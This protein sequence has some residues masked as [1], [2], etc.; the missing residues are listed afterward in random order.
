MNVAMEEWV[1]GRASIFLLS[2]WALN[3]LERGHE[4]PN[5]IPSK[6]NGCADTIRNIIMET[7][8]NNIC[9]SGYNSPIH[10]NQR[11]WAKPPCSVS[12]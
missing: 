7:Y 5:K 6:F 10:R 3:T 12:L 1:S 11:R 8:E 4:D 9:S 2:S